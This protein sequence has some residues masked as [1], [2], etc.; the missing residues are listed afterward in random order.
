[1]QCSDCVVRE[2]AW[3]Q[4]IHGQTRRRQGQPGR[5][6]RLIRRPQGV[7]LSIIGLTAIVSVLAFLSQTVL[8]M[9]A[10][11]PDVAVVQPWRLISTALVH[12]GLLHLALNML[13]LWMLGPALEERFGKLPFLAM[14]AVTAFAGSVAVP[15]LG[16]HNWV[17][18][19]SGAVFGLFGVY[20]GVQRMIGRIDPQLLIIVGI[21]L[22]FGFVVSGV[23]WQAH[24]GGL[25]AG[26]MIGFGTVWFARNRRKVQAP[27]WVA[28]GGTAAVAAA[29]WAAWIA[30]G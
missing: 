6:G 5:L 24:V 13:V 7:T 20:I 9:L 23:A 17:V 29:A 25:I 14:Y 8:A 16:S 1:M 12:G 15:L 27:A 30:L 11:Q 4:Q 19:A 21:N 18:G 26:F 28:I 22:V 10:Y 2:R 3:Q